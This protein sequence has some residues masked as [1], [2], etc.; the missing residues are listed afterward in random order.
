MEKQNRLLQFRLNSL[1]KRCNAQTKKT[2]QE[3]TNQL[4]STVQ[5]QNDIS[6]E[7]ADEKA[8]IKATLEMMAEKHAN[9]SELHEIIQIIAQKQDVVSDNLAFV[10]QSNQSLKEDVK[11]AEDKMLKL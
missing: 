10:Q 9:T 7:I 5:R 6:A 1:E 8:Q 3:I 11:K 2:A 4:S